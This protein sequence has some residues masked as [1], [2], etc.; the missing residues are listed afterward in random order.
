MKQVSETTVN[1]ETRK[2]FTISGDIQ[3]Q[4]A[5]SSSSSL[6]DDD[7]EGVRSKVMTRH[8]AEE[9]VD[10]NK[11]VY[12]G[13]SLILISVIEKRYFRFRFFDYLCSQSHVSI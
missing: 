2:V 11:Q 1:E 10:K 7:Q 13:K 9:T 12:R 5:S 8:Y 4:S 6:S 3:P